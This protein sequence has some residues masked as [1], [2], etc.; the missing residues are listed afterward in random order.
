MTDVLIRN[1]PEE[2]LRR[3][4]EK[5]ARMGLSRADY[6]KRQIAQD[7]RRALPDQPLTLDDFATFANLASDLL[8]EDV[9]REAWS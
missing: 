1:V 6:L 5:A 2:D 8:D 9:M 7:A 3:I 4:D